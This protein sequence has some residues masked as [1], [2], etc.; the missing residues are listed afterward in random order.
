M[1][2]IVN[3]CGAFVTLTIPKM[4]QMASRK[5][6]GP[7]KTRSQTQSPKVLG[8]GIFVLHGF[9]MVLYNM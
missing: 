9:Y 1:P 8:A 5:A 3:I 4:H 6:F 7:P 2:K